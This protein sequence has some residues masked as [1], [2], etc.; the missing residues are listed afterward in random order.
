MG[1]RMD[2]TLV[3]LSVRLFG[4][5]RWVFVL[6]FGLMML[7]FVSGVGTS[8]MIIE[9]NRNYDSSQMR[10]SSQGNLAVNKYGVF[11]LT[12]EEIGELRK[13]N[14]IIV[15]K[16][17]EVYA[18]L[19]DAVIQQN[20]TS[21]WDLKVGEINLTGSQKSVCIID[22]GVDLNHSDLE[23]KIIAQHC[24]CA[25]SNCCP[26]GTSEDTNATDDNG[27]GTHVAGIVAA[28]GQ[29]SGVGVGANLVV[30]KALDS[31]G[32][33]REDD[34]IN[35]VE[36]C[37]D[38][39]EEY[40]ITA[41]SMSF[42]GCNSLNLDLCYSTICSDLSTGL[43]GLQSKIQE[44]ID[45]NISVVIATGNEY[46][47]GVF[48][49]DKIS[50]PS[51]LP[52]VT[53]VSSIDK[54]DSTISYFANRNLLVKL[55]G[56][57]SG[58]NS[59]MPRYDVP[60]TNAAYMAPA[61]PYKNYYDEMSG[62]SM[63][64]PM[65][66]GAIAIMSQ[67][68]NLSRQKKTP[69][70]VEDIFYDTGKT[71]SELGINYSR[72]DVYS[73]LLSLDVDAPNVTLVSP[74]DNHINLSVNQT[75]VC[76]ATDWQL[77]NVTLSVWNSTGL[78]Y[79]W[80]NNLTGDSNE[81]SFDL[82]DMPENNYEWNCFVVDALGNS[83]FAS[84][85]YS[86]TIGGI[87][88][89]LDSPTNNTHTNVNETNFT[90]NSSSDSNYELSNVTF[91]L[92]NSTG[93]LTNTSIQNVSGFS[94]SS[95]FNYTFIDEG[96]YSWS[97]LGVNNGSNE[98]WAANNFS[99]T[100]DVTSPLISSLSVD[101][102]TTSATVT[103]TTDE[104]ANS[105]IYV[106]GGSWSNSS[107][108]VTSHSIAI[109]GLSASTAYIYNVTSCDR[110]GNCNSSDSSFTTSAAAVAPS[111]PSGSS[112]S[113]STSSSSVATPVG[114]VVHNVSVSEVSGGY[115]KSLKKDDK[116]NFS[117]YDFNGGRHLLT[118]EDVGVDYVNLTIESDPINFALGIGQS[119]K[120]NLTSPDYYDLFI[121]L[122]NISNSSAELT[123]QLINE[124]IE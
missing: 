44:A 88:I 111:S 80:T 21:A 30:V 123:I 61:T 38:N 65:V 37:V 9:P 39:S 56:I 115:T 110:A 20:V 87:E 75:F 4:M 2:M 31:D 82:T 54:D 1:P 47:D 105:S 11:D 32:S 117:I 119:V 53:R 93:D 114:P 46:D 55:L 77:A 6:I 74:V 84:A 49:Q 85:N 57:G 60:L 58:V 104:V 99:V 19:S 35:A 103:W 69:S 95:I 120:L 121:G 102:S 51:C 100:Y 12:N 50:W 98:S 97:C 83:A 15:R 72:I 33:G 41:I 81:S 92:W 18:F 70:E 94:N 106:S 16:P 43:G 101:E 40:N 45:K 7:G 124:P 13:D 86:L 113:S 66:A 76:N 8:I 27:H 68:L 116:I 79:N 28:S 52:S 36:W 25:S 5:N 73:A 112:S 90:C 96:N 108:N 14:S 10:I 64:T 23:D 59:T 78:Y 34:M 107:D 109:S 42:G 22:T 48:F 63:A 62:T 17:Y 118:V 3:S 24:F 71:I 91:Y 89:V 26:D 67:Y 29:V 122:N